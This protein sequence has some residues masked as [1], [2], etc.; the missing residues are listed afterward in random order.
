MLV[1][2][3]QRSGLSAFLL[4]LFSFK[5]KKKKDFTTSN[6]KGE[7]TFQ[8]NW[9]NE[10]KQGSVVSDV[11]EVEKNPILWIRVGDTVEK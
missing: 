5:E 6:K 3:A 7:F 8:E 1:L 9:L 11:W 10:F 4:Y 2:Y